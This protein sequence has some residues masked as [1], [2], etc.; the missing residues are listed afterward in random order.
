MSKDPAVFSTYIQPPA[1][2]PPQQFW[3]P[4]LPRKFH[5]DIAPLTSMSRL[6]GRLSCCSK[7]DAGKKGRKEMRMKL[8]NLDETFAKF[9][10]HCGVMIE[11]LK[12]F[13]QIICHGIKMQSRL[14]ISIMRYFFVCIDN[15]SCRSKTL[16]SPS[17]KIVL[18]KCV[19]RN[20]NK[21]PR[22]ALAFSDNE[23]SFDVS[24]TQILSSHG[25]RIFKAWLEFWQL[26]PGV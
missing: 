6:S 11:I 2:L 1:F 3:N 12:G 19:S 10:S 18:Q 13:R 15:I 5:S 17:S 24:S 20:S 9:L 21:T 26:I 4:V 23:G 14:N 25:T 7:L 22:L 8:K 16:C